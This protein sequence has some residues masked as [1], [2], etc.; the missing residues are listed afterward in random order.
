MFDLENLGQ[1]H[2]VQLSQLPHSMKNVNLYIKVLLAHFSLALAV[3]EIF[4]IQN[5]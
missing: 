5:S 4:A 1:G 3:F 2:R